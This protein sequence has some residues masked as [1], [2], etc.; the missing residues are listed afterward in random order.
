[1]EMKKLT[2]IKNS[3]SRANRDYQTDADVIGRMAHAI[4][5]LADIIDAKMDGMNIPGMMMVDLLRE[6][7]SIKSI[8]MNI[9]L[10]RRG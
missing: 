5:D 2:T 6:L 1:M 3:L 9:V 4:H 10:K 8:S 7:T